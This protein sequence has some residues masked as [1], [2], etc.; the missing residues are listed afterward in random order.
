MLAGPFEIPIHDQPHAVNDRAE[1]ECRAH[2][3]LLDFNEAEQD[4]HDGVQGDAEDVH[5][6]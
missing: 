6:T 5:H 3:D 1:G 4:D 2:G